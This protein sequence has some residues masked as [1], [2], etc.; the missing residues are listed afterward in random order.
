MAMQFAITQTPTGSKSASISIEKQ[1]AVSNQERSIMRIL[2]QAFRVY[3]DTMGL[4]KC[5]RFYE[6]LQG[7]KCE[8]R[9][10]IPETGVEAAKVGGFLILA[11]DQGQIEAVRYV[12][13]IFYVDSLDESSDWLSSQGADIVHKPRTVTG[14]KNLTARHADGLVVEYFEA[15]VKENK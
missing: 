12:N 8:R 13:A 9:V 4:E 10:K 3:T 11:G 15:E 5:I 1:G 14:G 7:L 6:E 2:Q